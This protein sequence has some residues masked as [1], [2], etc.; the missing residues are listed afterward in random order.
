MNQFSHIP[1]NSS[2]NPI[3]A[4]RKYLIR[5]L[6]Q[7]PVAPFQWGRALVAH[8]GLLREFLVREIR[9]RFAGSVGGSLWLFVTPLSHILI[10][11]F[12]F[13]FILKIRLSMQEI[14]TE[15]FLIFLLAGLFPWMAFS[16]GLMRCTGILV[17]NANII[18]KVVFPTEVLPTVGLTSA[19]LL[20]GV[21]MGLF[22]GYLVW[23]GF[24]SWS[25]VWLPLV[26]V[27]FFLFALGIGAFLA[28]LCVFLRDTQQIFSIVTF[29]WF[30]LTPIVYPISL[31]PEG[32]RIYLYANPLYPF[33]ELFRTIL[34]QSI[35][36]SLLTIAAAW[37]A[38]TV[39]LG[40]F[41]F[42]R[43]KHSF[44]DVL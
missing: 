5:C 36:F 4:P 39:V 30:Y 1:N 22:L 28:A 35:D 32:F 27:L 12:V 40:G 43:A 31:I 44:A 29:V 41:F 26:I 8:R 18:T 20:N 9:G 33:V 42:E 37:T 11:S 24:A 38:L 6:Q 17:E 16:E 19:F 21:G 3:G 13:D 7:L 25:W 14:G 2:F 10:Y 23:A 34:L 15:S